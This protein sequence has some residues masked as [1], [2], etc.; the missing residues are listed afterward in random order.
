MDQSGKTLTIPL[1]IRS[2]LSEGNEAKEVSLFV[3]DLRAWLDLEGKDREFS[4]TGLER[5]STEVAGHEEEAPVINFNLVCPLSPGE[6]K[7]EVLTDILSQ[8]DVAGAAIRN[9]SG[10]SRR[11]FT[12]RAKASYAEL[13]V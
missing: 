4:F 13:E 9:D 5:S 3:G 11:S 10:R 1:L 8:I 12:E 7:R 6:R 2:H